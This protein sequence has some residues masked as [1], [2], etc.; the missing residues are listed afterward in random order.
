[1]GNCCQPE[2]AGRNTDMSMVKSRSRETSP[3][4]KEQSVIMPVAQ[5][6][7]TRNESMQNAGPGSQGRIAG[8]KR[9]DSQSNILESNHMLQRK[10]KKMGNI[11]QIEKDVLH[12]NIEKL[13]RKLDPKTIEFLNK[14]FNKHF[15]LAN[16]MEEEK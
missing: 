10:E 1:M 5:Y 4:G 15:V 14:A 11:I 9:R 7:A 13:E 16:L 2:V 3:G 6:P 8:H 12:E